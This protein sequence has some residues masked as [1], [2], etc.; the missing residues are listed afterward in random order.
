MTDTDRSAS[1]LG[2]HLKMTG[3]VKNETLPQKR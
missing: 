1:Y 3:A 2:L